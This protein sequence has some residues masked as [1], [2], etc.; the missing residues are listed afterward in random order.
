MAESQTKYKEEYNMEIVRL[1]SEGLS[2]TQMAAHF[3][4]I[5]HTLSNW[6]K[7]Y[8][9]FAEAKE[10]A[11]TLAEAFWEKV[12]QQG[13]RGLLSKFVPVSWIYMMKCRYKDNW[14]ENT[15]QR[16]ELHNTVKG[17]TD[18]ELDNALKALVASKKIFK[19]SNEGGSEAQ[20]A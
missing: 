11:V 9:E 10:L 14:K 20:A 13:T 15:D 7:K 12:G 2:V 5:P 1:G 8:P 17:L 16:V 19:G 3:K 18:E 6:A 4:V